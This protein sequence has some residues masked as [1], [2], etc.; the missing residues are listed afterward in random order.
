MSLS[1]WKKKGEQAYVIL[2]SGLVFDILHSLLRI[3]ET[4]CRGNRL[5][6]FSRDSPKVTKHDKAEL[7]RG[8]WW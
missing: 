8:E 2:M 3:I 7:R 6:S 4:G 5:I 1:I